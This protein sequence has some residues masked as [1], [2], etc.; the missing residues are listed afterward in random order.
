[1][2]IHTAP[3]LAG[4]MLLLILAGCTT[5][6]AI[7]PGGITP[8]DTTPV[9]PAASMATT[10][11]SLPTVTGTQAPGTC[12]ADTGS[13]AANCGGCGYACPANAVCQS[14]QCYCRDGYS[15]E[16]NQCIP[17]PASPSGN[18]CPEGMSPCPDGYCY[19]LGSSAQNCGQCGNACAPGMTCTASACTAIPVETTTAPAMTTTTA[20]VTT[21]TTVSPTTS[22]GVL[23]TLTIGP[24]TAAKAC[25]LKGGTYCDGACVNVTSDW[26][27]CGSCMKVCKSLAPT[28]CNGTCVDLQTDE[29]NCGTCGHVCPVL[30]SCVSG[31]CKSKVVVTT[32]PVKV[33]TTII[34]Q[35]VRPVL[36]GI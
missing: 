34:Y 23:T 20:A 31:S 10:V 14:G 28:C 1:M 5:N 33:L 25:L 7:P 9:P 35:P 30:T 18:G 17:V 2:Q 12:T 4:V 11:P 27:N 26:K 3:L 29:S 8:T 13:D 19:E 36:P 32:I 15:V 21:T 24:I 6:T 22:S 16:N